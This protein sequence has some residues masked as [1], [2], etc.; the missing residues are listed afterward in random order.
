MP[1]P[2]SFDIN[3]PVFRHQPGSLSIST[4]QSFDI[5]P[6]GP[7]TLTPRSFDVEPGLVRVKPMVH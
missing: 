1:A 7:S 5:D 2:R 6:S 3:P 4:W